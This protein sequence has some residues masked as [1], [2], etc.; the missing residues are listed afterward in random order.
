M[1]T[2]NYQQF[3]I[4]VVDLLN[5]SKDAI[6]VHLGLTVFFLVV[7]L[8]KRGNI[9]ATC[10]VPVVI[11]A[12]GMEAADLYDDYQSIGYFRWANSAHDIINTILWPALIILL[13][14]IK[15]EKVNNL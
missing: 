5:L 15:N 11:L 6:H 13:A 14:K 3:K 1:Q 4:I 2:S 8:W 9:L 10:I 12:L 7:L